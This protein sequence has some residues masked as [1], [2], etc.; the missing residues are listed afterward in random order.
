ML[1]VSSDAAPTV[2]WFAQITQAR[3][4]V[5]DGR[6]EDAQR[7]N[8][9]ALRQAQDLGE[10]DGANWWASIAVVIEI[11]RGGAATVV[12]VIGDFTSQYPDFPAWWVTHAASLAAVGRVQEA[13]E[14]LTRHSADP[15][16]LLNDLF[17]FLA[18][19]VLAWAFFYLNDAHAATRVVAAL[20]PYRD[21]WAHPYTVVSGPV[22]MYLAMCVAATGDHDESVAL[23][24]ESDRMLAELGCHGLL[25]FSA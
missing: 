20:R 21:Y 19:S 23:F 22:T 2:Q 3:V 9:D 11:V 16:E 17:P 4:A 5:I 12:D 14:V 18:V 7:I 10:P 15:D 6:F 1:A 8:D 24:E 13:H 25:P